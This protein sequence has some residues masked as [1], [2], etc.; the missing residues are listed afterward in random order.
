MDYQRVENWHKLPELKR[1][2]DLP[3]SLKELYYRGRWDAKIFESTVAIVGSRRMSEYGRRVLEKMI[4][5][6]LL[7]KKTIISGFMYGVDQYAHQMCVEGGGKTIAVLGWGIK[8]RLQMTDDRLQKKIIDSGGL[9]ISEWEEQMAT[10]WTFPVR[11]RIV[12][13]LADE[14]IV[15]EAATKSGSLITA[16]WARKLGR[17]L[18]AVPGPITSRTSAGTNQL[19][20]SGQAKMWLGENSQDTRNK[21]QTNNNDPIINLLQTE[22]LT[23]DEVARKMGKP[24]A[25]VGAQLSLLTLAGEVEERGGKYYSI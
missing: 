16:N 18:W 13:V 7:K 14:V 4:P 24:V 15:V 5:P 19:I 1:L 25:E 23:A 3:G 21:K 2:K 8:E 10:L 20:A 9:I 17:T 22:E 6:L 12:A 11:N